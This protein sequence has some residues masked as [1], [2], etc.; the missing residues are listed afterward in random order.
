LFRLGL[1]AF[2]TIALVAFLEFGSR[3]I[4]GE[5][6]AP[7]V[8]RS[9]TWKVCGQY[10]RDNGWI[11]LPGA[12]AHI[13]DG[14]IDYR[15]R[16]NSLGW[17]D[18]ERTLAKPPG[19]RRV[20]LL[21][22]SVTWGWGVDNGERYSDILERWLGEKVELINL[23][24]PGYGTDQ[25]YW[26]LSER[27]IAYEPDAVVLCMIFN[28]LLEVEN[29]RY[30]G[31]AK[32]R[33]VR[34]GEAWVVENRPVPDTQG[35]VRRQL[36]QRWRQLVS[37]SALLTWLVHGRTVEEPVQV[38]ANMIYRE[39]KPKWLEQIREMAGRVSDPS[40][41]QYMLLAKVQRLCEERGLPLLVFS[42]AH[43]H[44]QYLYEP[45]FPRP[46]IDD[47]A[48]F[49]NVLTRNLNQA[50]AEIG[51]EMISLDAAML[52]ATGEG[53]RLHCGDGHLNRLGNELVAK[54]LEPVLRRMLEL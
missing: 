43:K 32:G 30:Y 25:Q 23:A 8:M 13:R 51:I 22:D 9:E 26:T 39:P 50:A 14:E 46:E 6:Y 53:Q 21:G 2:T 36:V 1:A 47:P 42:I 54:H 5:R 52:R 37:D 15:V 34:A 18:P 11:N 3:Q 29:D 33:F 35:A 16:I 24:V 19:V 31:M 10:D 41:V 28:D 48:T 44:D 40:S 12:R 17:R 49:M 45:R 38:A 20:V 4:L 27:G 7:G